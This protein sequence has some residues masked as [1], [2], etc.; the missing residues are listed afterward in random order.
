MEVIDASNRTLRDKDTV[1]DICGVSV[2][3]ASIKAPCYNL[4]YTTPTLYFANAANSNQCVWVYL[5]RNDEAALVIDNAK[6]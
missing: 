4:C 6:N 2:V 1:T 5:P 3:S